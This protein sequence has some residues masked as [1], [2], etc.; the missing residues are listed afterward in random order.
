MAVH[1]I[2]DAVAERVVTDPGN[3]KRG[4]TKTLQMPGHVEG[5]T[6]EYRLTIR[7][8]VIQYF[9]ENNR[10]FAVEHSYV[11]CRGCSVSDSDCGPFG[12][13]V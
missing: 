6:T 8:T 12:N 2:P 9:T 13:T 1:G 3:E 4:E 5:S 10:S 11:P 7:E